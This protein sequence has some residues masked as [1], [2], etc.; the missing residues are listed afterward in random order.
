MSVLK[1]SALEKRYGPVKALAGIDLVVPSGSRTAIVG[2]SGCGKTTLL[3]LIA[4]FE[5]PS[6][7]RIVLDDTEL[8]G[9]GASAMPAHRRAIGLVAQDGALFPHLTIAE[10]IGFGIPRHQPKRAEQVTELAYI[11]GLDK[12]V[13]KRR[14]HELS[15]GQQQRVALARALA[16]EPSLVILDEPFSALD[17]SLRHETRS[18]VADALAAA[19]ATS[20]LVTHD[21]PEAMT[22]GDEVAVMWQGLFGRHAPL[23]AMAMLKVHLDLIFGERSVS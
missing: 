7:G 8:A 1:I 4:G 9:D 12:T 23:D 6:A 15:G 20:V 5:A 22:L 11:V 18:A 14:P 2:P 13:L 10:N 16:P 21:Q 19:G 3:R 17:T